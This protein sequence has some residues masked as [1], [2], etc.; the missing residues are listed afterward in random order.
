MAKEALDLARALTPGEIAAARLIPGMGKNR[1]YEWVH[2]RLPTCR[3]GERVYVH[4]LWVELELMGFDSR[5]IHAR[6][7]ARLGELGVV[8]LVREIQGLSTLAQ[9]EDDVDAARD[10]ARW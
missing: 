7:E 1:V 6:L 8:D 3:V 9:H 5:A 4:R 2:E 10:G